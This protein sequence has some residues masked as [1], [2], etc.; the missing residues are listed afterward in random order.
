MMRRLSYVNG[1]G[2][3]LV[4]VPCRQ[5]LPKSACASDSEPEYDPEVRLHL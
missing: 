5:M 4:H 1:L 3:K 2:V